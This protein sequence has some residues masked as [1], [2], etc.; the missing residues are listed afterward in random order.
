M[1]KIESSIKRSLNQGK[2]NIPLFSLGLILLFVSAWLIFVYFQYYQSRFYPKTY[3][4]DLNIAGLTQAEAKIKILEKLDHQI[5]FDRDLLTLFYQ[6]KKIETKLSE[7]GIKDNLDETLE[8]VFIDS[9]SSNGLKRIG[10]T[11]NSNF[12]INRNY[13]GL[14]YDQE[15]IK[16]VITVLKEAVDY[17]G[18]KPS[19][20]L[21]NKEVQILKGETS[22][23]LQIDE[24]WQILH[25]QVLS[26]NLRDL[27]AK[28]LE[29]EALVTHSISSLGDLQI[30]TSR[31]R[32]EKFID[33]KITL[34][35]EYQ[36]V[37][38][39]DQDLINF[40][41]LPK[42]FDQE[43][44]T[45][46]LD[47]LKQQINR[48]SSDAIF[49]YD[50]NTLEVIDFHPDQNGLEIDSEAVE[51]IIKD[52]LTKI[53]NGEDVYDSFTLPMKS[54]P[55]NTTLEKT[56]NLGIKE[57]IGFGESWYDHSIPN[58]IFN[59]ALA[60]GRINNHIV[61]PGEEFSFNKAIGEISD[62]TGY[63][64]AYIIEGG[65][66]KLAPGGGVCQVS[67][68]LFRSLLNS[69]LEV[70]RRLPHA[71][72]VSYYEIGNEPGFD[73]TVFEGETDLRF[74]NDTTQH[75]LIN[76]QTNSEDLYMFCKIY[77]TSDGRYT[78]IVDYK[79]WGQSS[80][81][82]T[83]YIPDPSL[84]PG[85]LKQIDWSAG[86]IKSEYTNIIRNKNGEEIRRD[87]YNSSYRPWAAKYLQG[88]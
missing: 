29:V 46:F 20:I 48:P 12:Y 34:K 22:N 16:T 36:K 5:N 11:I 37:E 85:Q 17:A 8:K 67:S 15:K 72:R 3:I 62:R 81:L 79:K 52:F 71:Y 14:S 25:Q 53:E 41:S 19:A 77:G 83:V 2:Q 9:H 43:K 57:V 32:A 49:N 64:N 31:S 24:T 7:L 30:E 33:K 58:R 80:A 73:A 56:N 75:V 61:K 1:E 28:D 18:E 66:T 68:T 38:L 55:A 78:E 59:V 27:E 76:C 47:Q 10:Q 88:I 13:V 54:S 44:I 63:K 40:L 42:D 35:Y 6:D 21:K 39:I 74:I 26:K 84:K 45:T 82:P 65:Q 69:G 86:G 51:K 70:T 87:K 4:N 50:E 23:D 60:A